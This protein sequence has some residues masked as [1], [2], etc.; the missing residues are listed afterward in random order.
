[1]R[2][3]GIRRTRGRYWGQMRVCIASVMKDELVELLG[4][5]S[6]FTTCLVRRAIGSTPQLGQKL[7]FG[8]SVGCVHLRQSHP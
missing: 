6:Y 4:E 1:M 8:N 3:E 7:V 2:M 5:S